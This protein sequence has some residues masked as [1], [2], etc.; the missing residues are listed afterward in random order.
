MW[1]LL[2]RNALVDTLGIRLLVLE[3]DSP[4]P[5]AKAM[6]S[7][8]IRH[9]CAASASENYVERDIFR[10]P[11]SEIRRDA[12]FR[13]P[14]V[15]RSP[16]AVLETA[17]YHL[18]VGHP[19]LRVNPVQP[20]PLMLVSGHDNTVFLDRSDYNWRA[21][22]GRLFAL[23]AHDV[24]GWRLALVDDGDNQLRGSCA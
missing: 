17:D 9:E 11:R 1:K 6:K 8:G 15:H 2:T 19:S 22:M 23:R 10:A 3:D 24:G 21:I 5:F 4:Q 18:G 16:A 14:L 7:F 13:P 20:I 12:R